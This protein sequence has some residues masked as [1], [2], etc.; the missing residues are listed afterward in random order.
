M[1]DKVSNLTEPT[2]EV[3]S[4]D[5]SQLG[6]ILEIVN[7]RMVMNVYIG[8]KGRFAIPD[9]LI[10]QIRKKVVYLALSKKEFTAWW[11]KEGR[12]LQKEYDEKRDVVLGLKL[13]GE[14]LKLFRGD[15]KL[16]FKSNFGIE[17]VS[18]FLKN[19]ACPYC[20]SFTITGKE[21]I[22][23]YSCG[24]YLVKELDRY[25]VPEEQRARFCLEQEKLRMSLPADI[26]DML[27]SDEWVYHSVGLSLGEGDI[28]TVTSERLIRSR[29]GGGKSNNWEIPTD[30]LKSVSVFQKVGAYRSGFGQYFPS[31]SIMN[32]IYKGSRDPKGSQAKQIEVDLD[33]FCSGQL[34][35]IKPY[36]EKAMNRRKVELG[37]FTPVS[38]Y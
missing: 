32:V 8:R 27:H 19:N 23:C 20:G 12:R 29:P 3:R 25:A 34:E 18:F 7:G 5:E 10:K 17:A 14:D 6:S 1:I 38:D 21:Q 30:M 36:I 35:S 31:V 28:L 15:I 26:R 2:A 9:T 24:L 22:Y 11:K 37:E 16:A 4:S 13:V 33:K